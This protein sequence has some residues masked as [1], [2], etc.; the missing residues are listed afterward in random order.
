MLFVI[1]GVILVGLHFLGIG[2]MAQWNWELFGDLWKFVL[3]FILALVWWAWADG[4]GL[5]KR[6]EMEKDEERKA[7]RRRR[8]MENL[9]MGP[10]DRTRR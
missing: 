7:T 4:S 3:P 2:P 5:T 8:S 9:G 10:K 1:V 6:R